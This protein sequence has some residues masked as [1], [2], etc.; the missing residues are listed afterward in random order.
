M[1][2]ATADPNSSMFGETGFYAM[3]NNVTDIFIAGQDTT[4]SSILWTFLYL[5]HHPDVQTKVHQELDEV[6]YPVGFSLWSFWEL[7]TSKKDVGPLV[8]IIYF[9]GIDF[10]IEI[11][12]KK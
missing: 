12:D 1:I 3:F 9:R 4:S 5:L 6:S 11:L 10:S 8:R 2:Q 7:R